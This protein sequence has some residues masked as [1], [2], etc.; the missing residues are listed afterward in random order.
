VAEPDGADRG[1]AGREVRALLATLDDGEQ[2]QL[3]SLLR[4][5]LLV[6]DRP[7]LLEPPASE[8]PRKEPKGPRFTELPYG[9]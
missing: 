9:Y 5:M 6:I 2:E 4:R 7:G 8:E 1:Q 3:F